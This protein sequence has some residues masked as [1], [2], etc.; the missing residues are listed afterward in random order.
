MKQKMKDKKAYT[1]EI[2][3]V[4]IP[5]KVRKQ[6]RTNL[7]EEMEDIWSEGGHLSEPQVLFLGTQS[8]KPMPYRNSTAIYLFSGKAAV[9]MD[10]SDGT[11]GQLVDY[12]G[13]QEKV[14]TVVNKTRV[15]YIT[16]LHGDHNL[17]LPRFLEERDKL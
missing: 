5:S 1:K 9:L 14:D 7:K 16:H 17:G 4:M 2:R 13:N 10:V 11:Y 12:C 15:V 6:I 3:K 8:M